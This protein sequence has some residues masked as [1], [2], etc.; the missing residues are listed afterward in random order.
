MGKDLIERKDY[1]EETSRL[2][3]EEVRKIIEDS[4]NKAVTIL[5]ENI[6]ELKKLAAALLEREKFLLL[7]K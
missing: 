7:R 6:S 2:I 4:Y 3:D 5:K 1:S